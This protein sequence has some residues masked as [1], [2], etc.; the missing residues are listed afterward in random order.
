M[1]PFQNGPEPETPATLSSPARLKDRKSLGLALVVLWLMTGF[2][3]GSEKVKGGYPVWRALPLDDAYIHLVYA[4]SLSERGRLEYND[5]VPEAGMTSLLWAILESPFLLLGRQAGFS[6][7]LA[8]H[9][10]N[11]LLAL[12]LALAVFFWARE[13]YASAG[14]GILAA[15]AVLLEPALGFSRFSGMEVLLSAALLVAACFTWQ[16]ARYAGAGIFLALALLARPENILLLGLCLVAEFFRAGP[17]RRWLLLLLPPVLA[18]L[19][20]ALLNYSA[21]GRPLPNTFYVKSKLGLDLAETGRL[22]RAMVFGLPFFH[23]GAGFGLNLLGAG[24]LLW[25]RKWRALP[26]VVFP[27]LLVLSVA[28]TRDIVCLWAYVFHRYFQPCIPFLLVPWAAGAGWAARETLRLI[29]SR[30]ERRGFRPAFAA[31]GLILVIASLIP[32][33]GRM[34]HWRKLLAWNCSNIEEIQVR[35]GHWI[36]EHTQPSDRIA[37]YDA[38]AIRFYG[39]RRTLDL[40]GLNNHEISA[41]P[42]AVFLREKP[43]YLV[44]PFWPGDTD[45]FSSNWFEYNLSPQQKIWLRA[46]FTTAA[47]RYTVTEGYPNRQTV[48]QISYQR[49]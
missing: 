26:L 46:V 4:R 16:Q 22:I 19:L 6:P 27:W 7:L 38:G 9:L 12:A 5:G 42:A 36:A 49:P 40:I 24:G 37:V 13:S 14:I 20:W 33:P 2:Y 31:A 29:R 21:T 45:P 11:Q 43:D 25:R 28:C 47:E 10:Q 35:L 23:W 18:G 48:Y 1:S 17:R 34:I 30:A 44:R 8:I 39:Q 41:A 15:G 32:W 3:F